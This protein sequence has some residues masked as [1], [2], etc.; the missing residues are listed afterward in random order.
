LHSL[1]FRKD[2][3]STSVERSLHCLLALLQL[4]LTVSQIMRRPN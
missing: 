3:P 2:L 4:L 1:L